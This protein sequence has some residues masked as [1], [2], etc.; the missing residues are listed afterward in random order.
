[1]AVESLAQ[2]AAQI[3]RLFVTVI[4]RHRAGL[5]AHPLSAHFGK[6]IT[7]EPAT[8]TIGDRET[9]SSVEP[10]LLAYE[11]APFFVGV[12]LGPD[13]IRRS[14]EPPEL[15]PDRRVRDQ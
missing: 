6:A 7:F 1:M 10:E 8:E 4:V 14:S 12:T 3:S 9:L 11:D 5:L 2:I 13:H 15:W